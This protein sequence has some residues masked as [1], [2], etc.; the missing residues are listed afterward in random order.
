MCS[1]WLV[2]QPRK[3]SRLLTNNSCTTLH[4]H[5]PSHR[6]G[7]NPLLD[8]PK[9]LIWRQK[10]M[11]AGQQCCNEGTSNWKAV[12]WRKPAVLT[13]QLVGE[14]VNARRQFVLSVSV[15]EL[16]ASRAA[17]QRQ[18]YLPN[19]SQNRLLNMVRSH[20]MRCVAL[21]W[22]FQLISYYWPA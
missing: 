20:R 10:Y 11:S 7:T 2:T 12:S 1:L 6:R 22:H 4:C 8:T 17:E 19:R 14:L 21:R 9:A 15:D 3:R 16:N 18:W 5:H 13:T